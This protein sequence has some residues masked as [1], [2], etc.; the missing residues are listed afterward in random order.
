MEHEQ[1]I[2]EKILMA[3]QSLYMWNKE[4]VWSAIPHTKESRRPKAVYYAAASVALA[5]AIVFYSLGTTHRQ[6]LQVQLSSIELAIERAQQSRLTTAY[7]TTLVLTDKECE[8]PVE[9][10][11]IQPPGKYATRLIPS[12]S[13][14]GSEKDEAVVQSFPEQVQSVASN[15]SGPTVEAPVML[16]TTAARPETPVRPIIGES[17]SIASNKVSQG[18]HR[19]QLR[20][21]RTDEETKNTSSGAPTTNLAGI[22]NQ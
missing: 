14:F 9:K 8:N 12:P 2:R 4:F 18:D 11:M 13:R 17:W 20:L 6:T 5:A 19:F 15:E 22:N 1:R 21:F 10:K 7:A 3:E 16:P